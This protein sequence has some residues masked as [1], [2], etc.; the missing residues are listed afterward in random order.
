M[1]FVVYAIIVAVTL[2]MHPRDHKTIFVGSGNPLCHQKAQIWVLLIRIGYLRS[3]LPEE[4]S[5]FITNREPQ[6]LVCK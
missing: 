2:G 5:L 4:L 1:I 3:A 6:N